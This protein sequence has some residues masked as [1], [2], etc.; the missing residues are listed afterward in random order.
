MNPYPNINSGFDAA[1]AT[2]RLMDRSANAIPPTKLVDAFIEPQSHEKSV[3]AECETGKAVLQRPFLQQ[4]LRLAS[5][6]IQD[7]R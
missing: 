7:C 2:V 4:S 3:S 5:L 6:K 1:L